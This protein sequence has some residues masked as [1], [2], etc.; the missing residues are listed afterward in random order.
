LKLSL[1][2][3]KYNFFDAV[4]QSSPAMVQFAAD[5][6]SSRKKGGVWSSSTLLVKTHCEDEFYDA[7]EHSSS[8]MVQFAM[9]ISSFDRHDNLPDSEEFHKG[10]WVLKEGDK[11]ETKRKRKKQQKAVGGVLKVGGTYIHTGTATD[12]PLIGNA[13]TVVVLPLIPDQVSIEGTTKMTSYS[14]FGWRKEKEKILPHGVLTK[15]TRATSAENEVSSSN[16]AGAG[17][18]RFGYRVKLR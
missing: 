10:P 5:L 16:D 1:C 17:S 3:E 15:K 14:I 4:E 6:T 11:R 18:S 7:V 8:A 12:V 2:F 13:A 9:D